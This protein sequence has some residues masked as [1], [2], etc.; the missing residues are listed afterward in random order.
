MKTFKQLMRPLVALAACAAFSQAP[1]WSFTST[2]SFDDKDEDKKD[3]KKEEED[4]YF[5]L[6]G[7][8]V[9][10]GLG[11]VLRGATV[12]SK[13]GKI[14]DI[15]YELYLPDETE[16][17]DVSGMR[18]YPGMVALS[19]STQ[20]TA[21]SFFAP[22]E[23][24]EPD[25]PMLDTMALDTHYGLDDTGFEQEASDAGHVETG[26]HDDPQAQEEPGAFEPGLASRINDSFDPFSSFMVL[27]LAT[28]IT[29]ADQVGA[30]VKLKRDEIKDV[31]M[32]DG[33]LITMRWSIASPS[34]IRD[35]RTKFKV[36]SEYLRE[37]RAWGELSK[38]ERKAADQ[39]KEPKKPRGTDSNV[40]KILTGERLARFNVNEREELLGIA[41]FAQQ[42]RFKPVIYGCIEGWTVAEEL[43][44][45]GAMVVVTP[46]ARRPKSELLMRAGGSSI[47]NAA[48][49][50]AAGVQVAIIPASTGFA[51]QGM[52]GRD[53]LHLPT[54]AAFGVRGGLSEEAAFAAISLIPARILGVDHRV[55]T[56]EKG[57][58]MDVIVMD[59]D[60]LHYESFV[61]WA[62][63]DGKVAY[64]KQEEL[65]YAHIRPRAEQP[66][67]PESTEPDEEAS[68]P[69]AD[70]D[71]E[72]AED[73]KTEEAEDEE[74]KDE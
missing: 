42:Y 67:T 30:A 38:D 50:H 35:M 69:A 7:G 60:V 53:L 51:L 22:L 72:E 34:S 74:E 54:E 57:K 33:N 27:A 29:T 26:E 25:S 45:A 3:E 58:D 21:G 66:V 14:T 15:G 36:T 2:L 5:A 1:A 37:L 68:E 31:L 6:M 9:Y 39:E 20:I 46:R 44:R 70:E 23:E 61:Q 17:L 47:E 40:L 65:Y 24:G 4:R 49:L 62:V 43:G 19:S 71:S 73:P 63:V 48:I 55:G 10:T 32:K 13:N 52:T 64:D 8:D 16:K 59:G 12:L 56:L 11:G 28:G 18:V 41:L